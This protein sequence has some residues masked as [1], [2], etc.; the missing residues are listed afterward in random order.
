MST[1][2]KLSKSDL[3]THFEPLDLDS[4][5]AATSRHRIA[6]QNTLDPHL[7]ACFL[8]QGMLRLRRDTP[9]GPYL[10]RRVSGGEM[11]G[12]GHLLQQPPSVGQ[13]V[14]ETDLELITFD[15]EA[16]SAL[17]EASTKFQLCLLWTLWK[18]LSGKLRVANGRLTEFFT[19]DS[20]RTAEQ[21][22]DRAEP[23]AEFRVDLQAKRGLFAEQR[24][25]GLEIN[26]LTTLS[27]EERYD[28]GQA[29]FLEGEPAETMY[30]VLD[31]KVR[32]S[33]HI[34]GAGEEALSF[35]ERG[36]FFGEMALIERE[37]RSATAV[38]HG[39]SAIV[40]GIPREVLRG[41]LDIKKVSSTRL[42][43]LLCE[44]LARRLNELDDKLVGWHVLSAGSRPTP[45]GA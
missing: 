37:P 36:A 17:A 4:L 25:S 44:M 30:V 43:R 23:D 2:T 45:P 42:L 10:L 14:A 29:I 32:I 31:G 19:S 13:A 28:S 8:E 20:G 41:L 39:G 21:R 33:K 40:L 7:Q 5:R 1:A 22:P 15:G 6:K 11:F 18:S 27:K 35:L 26:F 24:L 16:V 38:A 9:Y 12:E 34:P 3:F